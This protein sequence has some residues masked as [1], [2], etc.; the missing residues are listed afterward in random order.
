MLTQ[1]LYLTARAL[2]CP[3][4][5]NGKIAIRTVTLQFFNN[6]MKI[7]VFPFPISFLYIHKY[8]YTTLAQY[9]VWSSAFF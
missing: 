4:N 6:G 1:E 2:I 3:R 8:T 9:N 7:I 5:Y